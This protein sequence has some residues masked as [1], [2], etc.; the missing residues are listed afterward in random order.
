LYFTFAYNPISTYTF[1]KY[2]SANTFFTIGQIVLNAITLVPGLIPQFCWAEGNNICDSLKAARTLAEVSKDF[3]SSIHHAD[4]NFYD[5]FMSRLGENRFLLG[6][7]EDKMTKTS[8]LGRLSCL[9]LWM[10]SHPF[11]KN[12]VFQGAMFGGALGGENGID[13]IMTNDTLCRHLLTKNSIPICLEIPENEQVSPMEYWEEQSIVTGSHEYIAVN[14]RCNRA[15][16]L[17]SKVGNEFIAKTEISGKILQLAIK[18]QHLFVRS[19]EK[20]IE[21]LFIYKIDA[22]NEEPK[23]VL[24]PHVPKWYTRHNPLC[25][26]ETHLIGVNEKGEDG[27]Q[28]FYISM[29]SLLLGH[30]EQGN[31]LWNEGGEFSQYPHLFPEGKNFIAITNE[32]ESCKVTKITLD[33][34]FGTEMIADIFRPE[35][36][37]DAIA[38]WAVETCLYFQGRVFISYR[39]GHFNDCFSSISYDLVTKTK[40]TLLNSIAKNSN[41]FFYPRFL[42][43]SALK[44]H[45]LC[46]DTGP[47]NNGY[48][49]IVAHLT[50]YDYSAK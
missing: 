22:L 20:K 17:F 27:C 14:P 45:F 49:S 19:V 25:F 11:Q 23:E 16:F 37:G 41:M 31:L 5:L 36:P 6:S 9:S 43:S 40:T 33:G 48:V 8:L 38:T 39:E 13:L 12:E 10:R 34:V 18:G 24:I 50:T 46:M 2:H 28:L 3:Y 44:V 30:N 21:K 1:H 4:V 47:L 26:G 35:N 42:V 32:N 29:K 7:L 15:I